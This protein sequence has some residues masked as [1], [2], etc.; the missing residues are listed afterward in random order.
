MAEALVRRCVVWAETEFGLVHDTLNV[1][2]CW[3]LGVASMFGGDWLLPV[4]VLEEPYPA[5]CG[6]FEGR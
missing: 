2:E 5:E 1:V 4:G 3:Q 6:G